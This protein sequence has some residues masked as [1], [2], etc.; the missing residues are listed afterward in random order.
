[1][2]ALSTNFC[3]HDGVD[4]QELFRCALVEELLIVDQGS[5]LIYWADSVRPIV[6]RPLLPATAKSF[7]ELD[8]A[9]VFVVSRLR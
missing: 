5:H 1:M 2:S 7:I 9:L 4:S 8:Q 6:T 3:A